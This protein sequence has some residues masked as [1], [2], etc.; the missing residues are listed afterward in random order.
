MKPP[1]RPNR[2]PGAGWLCLVGGGEFSFGETEEAD[3]A[4]LAKAP[5]GPIGFLPTAS[6]SADYGRHFSTYMHEV[7]GRDVEVIPVYRGRD[8]ARGKNAERI[9]SAA[10]VYLGGGV[11]DHLL[12]TLPG[13]A[14][15]EALNARL[16]GGGLVVAIAA[17]A[18]SAGKVARS[19]LTREAIPGL[20]WL[21][22]GVLEPNF[23]PGHDRRLRQLMGAPGVRWGMGLPAG[24]ALLLGPEG[25]EELVGTAFL[26]RDAD[27]DFEVLGN[28]T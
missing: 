5:E 28:P 21:P 24:S 22:D 10:V 18:Q 25:A 6:D 2:V 15:G 27:D 23:E 8:A 7:F 14:A 26:L 12:D 9:A 13:T 17:A 11:T 1:A 16:A 4:W 19:L 20:G 3:R